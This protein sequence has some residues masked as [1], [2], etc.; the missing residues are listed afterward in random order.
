MGLD[1]FLNK[2]RADFK[3][4]L[5]PEGYWRKAN[6]IHR[7]FVLH[8]QGNVD[9]CDEYEVKVDELRELMILCKKVLRDR[10]LAP[11]LLPTKEGFF[12]GN[13][14]YN[15]Y[16]FSDLKLTVKIIAN[17]IKNHEPGDTYYYQSSW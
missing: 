2:Q 6:A 15:Q 17:L 3:I 1:M 12:F 16:Y 7:W 5:D 13:Y 9:N 11:E 10:D 14:E 8:V 4:E